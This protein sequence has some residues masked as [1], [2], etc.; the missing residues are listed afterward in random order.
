[1][2]HAG[3]GRS[4]PRHPAIVNA[5]RGAARF[6][7]MPPRASSNSSIVT[8]RTL[9]SQPLREV[10]ISSCCLIYRPVSTPI[11]RLPFVYRHTSSSL[12]SVPDWAPPVSQP[13][14]PNPSQRRNRIMHATPTQFANNTQN[15]LRHSSLSDYEPNLASGRIATHL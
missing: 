15:R 14:T 6:C 1:M 4:T 5:W 12:A 11:G 3:T 13:R 10:S 7:E 9:L 8:R 2:Q